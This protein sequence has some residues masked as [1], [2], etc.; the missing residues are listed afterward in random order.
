[1]AEGDSICARIKTVSE[2]HVTTGRGGVNLYKWADIQALWDRLGR[3][4]PP[5]L[6]SELKGA[7]SKQVDI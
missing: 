3:E 4:L 5:K 6:P 2:P 1:M 7:G